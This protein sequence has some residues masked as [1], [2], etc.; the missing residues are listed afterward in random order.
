MIAISLIVLI[1]AVSI[2]AIVDL[3]LELNK[4]KRPRSK[5]GR[6]E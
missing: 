2:G 5:S 1:V 4:W 6:F 3:Q